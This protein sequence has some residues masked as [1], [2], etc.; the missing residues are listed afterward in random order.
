MTTYTIYSASNDHG[1]NCGPGTY[2]NARAGTAS[3]SDTA[4][5]LEVGQTLVTTNYYC[6]Q[7][8]MSFDTSVVPVGAPTSVTLTITCSLDNSS[9]L[10][11]VGERSWSGGTGD[12]VAGADLSTITDFSSLTISSSGVKTF[13]GPSNVAR[14]SAYK[15]MFWG[16]KQETNT[17]PTGREAISIT[18]SEATG[19]ADDP[20]LAIVIPDFGTL[21]ASIGE[22][23][24]SS[25]AGAGASATGG[26]SIG[27]ITSASTGVN[28][29]R[30]TLAAPVGD[31]T[32]TSA[33]SMLVPVNTSQDRRFN[34]DASTLADRTFSLN[35]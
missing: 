6:R 16:N 17:A 26:G 20:Y 25:T 28:L 13:T 3:K 8:F 19:T 1:V 21:T 23:G 11:N 29:A 33:A 5:G 18:S 15:L 14:S 22:F 12:F 24:I 35:A 9:T 30:G 7:A 34:F 4:T 2:A 27:E 32:S 31:I 10:I